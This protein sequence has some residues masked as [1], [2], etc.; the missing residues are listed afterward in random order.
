VNPLAEG[1]QFLP[2]VLSCR[3]ENRMLLEGRHNTLDQVG[4]RTTLDSWSI[5]KRTREMVAWML[6]MYE[7][8]FS[9]LRA[10]V[11]EVTH[12][13][14]VRMHLVSVAAFAIRQ[15]DWEGRTTLWPCQTTMTG[16]K[17]RAATRGRYATNTPTMDLP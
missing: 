7:L 10:G 6:G 5:A 2:W 3:H 15:S 4:M 17:R 8:S 1:A 9:A 11:L 13:T 16:G 12:A 14:I